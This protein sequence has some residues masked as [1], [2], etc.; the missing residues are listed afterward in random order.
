MMGGGGG[1]PGGFGNFYD[2][3]E[4]LEDKVLYAGKLKELDA[5]VK[6]ANDVLAEAVENNRKADAKKQMAEDM[7][8]QA[9]EK[10]AIVNAS[11]E[12]Q[13]RKEQDLISREQQ[14]QSDRTDL[15]TDQDSFADSKQTIEADLR[16]RFEQVAKRETDLQTAHAVVTKRHQDANAEIANQRTAAAAERDALLVKAQESFNAAALLKKE[17]ASIKASI[18]AR[19][20][21]LEAFFKK[22]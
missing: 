17:A 1:A 13:S 9:S 16:A 5:K 22:S 14:L 19:K 8:K 7:L 10:V 3:I 21:E 12:D 4:L 20:Q 6:A 15:R 11:K 2:L 18:E